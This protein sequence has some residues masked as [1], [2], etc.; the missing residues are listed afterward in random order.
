VQCIARV[1]DETVIRDVFRASLKMFSIFGSLSK[2]LSMPEARSQN[3][4]SNK[5]FGFCSHHAMKE[6]DLMIC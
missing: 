2:L 1:K 4:Y 5:N 3:E 6:M